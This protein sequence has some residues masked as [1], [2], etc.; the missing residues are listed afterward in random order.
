MPIG[1]YTNIC[2][3]CFTSALDGGWGVDGQHYFWQRDPVL[4]VQAVGWGPR[5]G[6]DVWGK[7]SP[8]G[9]QS[10]DCPTRSESVM[11]VEQEMCASEN[12]RY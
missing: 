5:T 8:T 6:P 11:F 9:I 2:V 10:P 7:V 3:L 12:G 1:Q 4:I